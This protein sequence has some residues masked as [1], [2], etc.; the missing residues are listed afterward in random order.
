MLLA[1]IL[2]LALAAPDADAPACT[3]TLSRDRVVA[4]ALAAS[5]AVQSATL[6]VEAL[7]GRRRAARTILPSNPTVEV[8]AAARHGLWNGERDVNVYGRLS[9]E[10]EVGGQ[11]RKRVAVVDAEI[12]GQQRR[13]AAARREVA[14]EALRAWYELVAASEQQAML[15]RVAEAARTL[16]E[17]AAAGEKAGLASGL[18]ADVAATAAVRVQRQQVEATRR[19]AAARAVLAGLLGQD[20]T[21]PALSVAPDM[22][23]IAVAGELPLLVESALQR[24]AE[25]AVIRA[26]QET[27]RRQIELL[28]RMRVPN[29]SLVAYAQRD[30]F[31]ERVLGGGLAVP[32]PLPAPLG[33]T[34]AGEIAE[35]KARVRQADAEL[36]RVRRQVR[37]EVVTAHHEVRAREAELALFDPERLRRAEAHITALGE[38]MAAGRLQIR[39][40]VILQQTFLDL[41]AAHL[42]A[43]RALGLASVELA[44]AAGLL[45]QEPAR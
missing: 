44:R 24:R 21:A 32:I 7:A 15:A 18:T 39:D 20:P 3:G 5:P 12:D 1:A 45:A 37:A 2:T 4:C 35:S 41:L 34:Y 28:K 19:V 42:E 43:R 27:S 22:T 36:E 40:A 16:V 25:L 38:E 17:L 33:R 6:G 29:P 14:A 13:V 11:R 9:Q 30:G 8:T 26:E 23:P 31:N 10:L